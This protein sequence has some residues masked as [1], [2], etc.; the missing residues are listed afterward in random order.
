MENW[1][2]RAEIESLEFDRILRRAFDEAV[3]PIT[4]ALAWGLFDAP[5]GGGR[6]PQWLRSRLIAAERSGEK[7]VLILAAALYHVRRHGGP[8]PSMHDLG[9]L[10]QSGVVGSFDEAVTWTAVL[11]ATC[12]R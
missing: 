5:D 8:A 11:N 4:R 3:E 1:E 7:S 10:F 12:R 2:E 9:P 6:F